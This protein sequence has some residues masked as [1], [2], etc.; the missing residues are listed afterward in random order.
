MK[1][2]M[3]NANTLF[4]CHLNIF[5]VI[6]L[7]LKCKDSKIFSWKNSTMSEGDKSEESLFKNIKSNE[8]FEEHYDEQIECE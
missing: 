3:L 7:L 8:N 4:W 6:L 2:K 1:Q 5:L